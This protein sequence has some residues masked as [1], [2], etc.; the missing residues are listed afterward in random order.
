MKTIIAIAV[1]SLLIASCAPRPTD[2]V[3]SDGKVAGNI[4]PIV[5]TQS[6]EGFEG[7]TVRSVAFV[8]NGSKP[9]EVTAIETSRIVVEGKTIWSFQPTSSGDRLDW[10]MPVG[11]RFNKRNYL[12]MN[13]S[14]YGG[15]IP[16]VSLW[17]PETNLSV[18]LAE[19][20]LKLVIGLEGVANLQDYR[21][22]KVLADAGFCPVAPAPY[23]HR[24]QF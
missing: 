9:V 17:T 5:S 14:D 3:I 2:C 8:N 19:P 1:S 15:G 11:K 24:Y 7:L 16:M 6:P 18:G 21:L 23:R 4:T 13:G 20:V 10:A 12:G 22:I